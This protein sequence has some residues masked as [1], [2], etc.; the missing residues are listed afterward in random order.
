L[1]A[2]GSDPVNHLGATRK[3]AATD[4]DVGALAPE[5]LGDCQTNIACGAGDQCSLAYESSAHPILSRCRE[6]KLPAPSPIL[7]SPE[8][9]VHRRTVS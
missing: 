8:V 7:C 5:C 2:G 6:L 4:N 1:S 3:A 9:L